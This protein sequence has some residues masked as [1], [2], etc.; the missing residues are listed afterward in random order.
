[1]WEHT[2]VQALTVARGFISPLAEIIYG[3]WAIRCVCWESNS[4]PLNK[5]FMDFN[6]PA[7]RE[8]LLMTYVNCQVLQAQCSKAVLYWGIDHLNF[9]HSTKEHVFLVPILQKSYKQ[10]K[11]SPDL[12]QHH[13]QVLTLQPDLLTSV[14]LNRIEGWRPLWCLTILASSLN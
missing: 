8:L 5:L 11:L 4:D 14:S 10:R 9:L 12:P 13:S 1:M 7:P 6:S 3:W 2:W